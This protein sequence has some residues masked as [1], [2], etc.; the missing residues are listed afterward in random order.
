MV[1]YNWWRFIKFIV[2]KEE[3]KSIQLE[4]MNQYA[5]LEEAEGRI[6]IPGSRY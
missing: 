5:L 4:E 3:C 2:P 6:R 1:H